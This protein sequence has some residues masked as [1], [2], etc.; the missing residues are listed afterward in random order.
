MLVKHT[1]AL[2][3]ALTLQMR[4][5]RYKRATTAA[6]VTVGASTRSR[7]RADSVERARH[8]Q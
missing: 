7:G 8:G 2:K 5:K 3:S 1:L 4:A 6:T